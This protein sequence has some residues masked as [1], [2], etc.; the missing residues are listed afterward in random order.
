VDVSEPPRGS[1]IHVAS[2]ADGFT[3]SW[4]RPGG[5][6]MRFFVVLF[7]VGWLVAWAVGLVSAI[8][9]MTSGDGPRLFLIGWLAAWTAGGVLAGTMAWLMVRPQ[10]PESVTLG[11]DSF[12]YD[13]GSAPP[14]FWNPFYM[15]RKSGAANPFAMIFRRRKVHVFPRSKTPEFVLEGA[16]EDQR[17]RFDDGADRVVIGETLREPEREWLAQV[18]KTWTNG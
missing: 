7:M 9:A 16:G 4:K 6:F 13:T 3:L 18:L 11:W 17:L 5:G 15:M 10:V 8:G 2:G 12:R 14:A 1:S